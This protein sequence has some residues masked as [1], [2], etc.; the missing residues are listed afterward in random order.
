MLEGVPHQVHQ[1]VPAVRR[2]A[3]KAAHSPC[4]NG[5]FNW[6]DCD[7]AVA[8]QWGMCSAVVGKREPEPC[9]RWAVGG[10]GYCAQHYIAETERAR[11]SE[12]IAIAKAQ[13]EARLDAYIEWKKT[14]PSVWD[15]GGTKKKGPYR[16]TDELDL[17]PA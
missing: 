15:T 8:H 11:A 7:A 1:L 13:L 10:E 2:P 14:H 9:S 17:A 3:H 6:S 12:R 16:I 4:P 5:V